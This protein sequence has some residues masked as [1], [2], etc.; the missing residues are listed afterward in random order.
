VL[1]CLSLLIAHSAPSFLSFL[2]YLL[3]LSSFPHLNLATIFLSL[4]HSLPRYSLLYRDS[5]ILSLLSC[6]S[7]ALSHS[8][9]S[10]FIHLPFALNLSASSLANP[11]LPSS[12]ILFTLPLSLVEHHHFCLLNIHF[13]LFLPH[14]LSQIMHHFFHFSFTLCHNYQVSTYHTPFRLCFLYHFIHI[15]HMY[16]K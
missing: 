13:Q 2:Q 9:S 15:C 5:L 14:I 11:F 4:A 12:L 7:V 6:L 16:R 10:T 8:L 1:N 3:S